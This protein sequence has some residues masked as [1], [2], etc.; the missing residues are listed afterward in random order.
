MDLQISMAQ[1]RLKNTIFIKNI[2]TAKNELVTMNKIPGL[3]PQYSH[4]PFHKFFTGS[5]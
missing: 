1:L 5:Q 3:L 2:F 4:F